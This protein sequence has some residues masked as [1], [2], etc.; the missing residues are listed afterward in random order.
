[1]FLKRLRTLGYNLRKYII[2]GYGDLSPSIVNYYNTHPEMGYE[3][4]GYFDEKNYPNT[5]NVKGGFQVLRQFI[6]DNQIDYVY[7]CLPYIDN[8]Q[9]QEIISHSEQ[10]HSQVK[11]LVDFTGF[12]NKGISIEYHDHLPII[13][14]STKPFSDLRTAVVK[15]TFDIVF[16][17]IVLL[18]CFPFLI[19]IAL[20][21]I[22]TS[23]GPIFYRSERIGLWGK[24]FYMFKF[25]SMSAEASKSKH[26]I[27][28]TGEDD[29]RINQWGRFMRKSRLDELPQFLNVLI[30]DMS[31]VGPRPGIPR[32]NKEVI[33]IAPEFERLLTIKPG[34]TSVGQVNY[35][36]AETPEE[37]VKRME[38]DLLYLNKYSLRMDIWLIFKTAKV[39]IQGK[40]K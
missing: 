21:T 23:K 40:G 35:G 38:F 13:N 37:M 1:M 20:I 11:L 4:Y 36:Y 14:L 33:K 17:I 18:I 2:V 28:S 8:K 3:F 16:S 12:M 7:C 15:R 39:M 32:Y 19:L 31:I 27:L 24:P 34:I 26:I 9:L 29:P 10:H 5:K 6:I 25:R 22:L 30:G